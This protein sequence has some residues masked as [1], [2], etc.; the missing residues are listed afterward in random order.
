[1]DSATD[2]CPKCGEKTPE[3]GWVGPDTWTCPKCGLVCDVQME[4]EYSGEEVGSWCWYVLTPA[5]ESP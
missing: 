2:E 4:S 1:M 5:K 3:W